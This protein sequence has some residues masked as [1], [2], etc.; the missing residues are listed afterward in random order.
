MCFKD[1]DELMHLLWACD[2]ARSLW[3]WLAARFG[4]RD[5]FFS[6]LERKGC[7]TTIRHMWGAAVVGRMAF[8]MTGWRLGYLAGPTHFVQACGKIQNQATSGASS[9]SQKAKVAALGL[10]Y[11]VLVGKPRKLRVGLCFSRS[12]QGSKLSDPHP[13]MVAPERLA[14]WSSYTDNNGNLMFTGKGLPVASN[15]WADSVALVETV[16]I[17][18]GKR[19]PDGVTYRLSSINNAGTVTFYTNAIPCMTKRLDRLNVSSKLN[20][21]ILPL[22]SE[23]RLA[24]VADKIVSEFIEYQ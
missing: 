23:A 7:S 6:S 8:V 17:T 24:F 21:Y 1:T 4:F 10:G 12:S 3:S 5:T 16:G 9:I 15:Y 13:L 19:W 20:A 14:V 18:D 2:F 11:A 22:I